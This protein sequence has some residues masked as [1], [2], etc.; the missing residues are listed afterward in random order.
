MVT[1]EKSQLK[2]ALEGAEQLLKQV[3]VYG[4]GAFFDERFFSLPMRLNVK[5]FFSSCPAR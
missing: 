1:K 3:S 4:N 5:L 2:E